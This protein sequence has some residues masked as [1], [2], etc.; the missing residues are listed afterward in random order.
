MGLFSKKKHALPYADRVKQTHAF[1]CERLSDDAL[2]EGLRSDC[3]LE[4][5][6]AT[7]KEIIR[8]KTGLVLFDTQLA[9]AFSLQKGRIAELPTGEGKTLA[10]V[11][12]AVCY[13][14]EGRR[15]H[16]LVFNDYLAK[17]DWQDNREIYAACGLTCG[18]IDQH[19]V[20]KERQAAY[21]CDITYVSA[22]EAGFD[23][24]RDFL[25]MREEDL[26]FPGFD[27]AIVDEADS[28]L[29]DESKTPLVLAGE[30]KFEIEGVYQVNACVLA[31]EPEDIEIEKSEQRVWLT[32]AGYDHMEQLLGKDLADNKNMDIAAEVQS[33]LEAHHL[34]QKDKDYIVKDGAVRIIEPTTGRVV[35]NKRY[36]D[37]LHR[38]VEVKEGLRT[39]PQT[40]V[41][42]SISMQDFLQ[43]YK[44][45]SGMTGTIATSKDEIYESFEL[46]VD[47]VPPHTPCVRNDQP[48]VVCLTAKKHREAVLKQVLACFEKGQPVLM[49]TGSV[50]ESELFSALFEKNA[51]PHVVLNAKNDEAEAELIAGAGAPGAVTISTNM[52]GRGVDIKLGGRNEARRDESVRAGGLYVLGTGINPCVRIDNQLRGRSGRQGDPGESRFFISMEDEVFASRVADYQLVKAQNKPKQLEVIVR[53]VQGEL[54]GEAAE[55]RYMLQRYAFI[56]E[57]QRDIV[58]A[59]R[60]RILKGEE[61]PYLLEMNH[62]PL[63]KK[64]CETAPR[65]G[66]LKAERQL[67]LFY[68]N[69]H[70]ADYLATMEAARSGIHFAVL[71]RRSPIDEYHSIAIG[72]YDE[73]MAEIKQDVL[74]ALDTLPITEN[75]VE[76][77]DDLFRGGTTTWTYMVDER[78]Y[79]FSRLPYL[80]NKVKEKTGRKKPANE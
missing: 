68:I 53:R 34:V 80:I 17:R 67:A 52:A 33:A 28:I 63:F 51:I 54:D 39:A 1:S 65:E 58:T 64:L 25:A 45:L 44:T 3:S 56:L 24:L 6:Y 70:W 20:T 41:F 72:A 26:V 32:D 16:I 27:T 18:Y 62:N 50:A 55:A 35:L 9:T 7:I 42:N 43:Q 66:V 79:Q 60:T 38:A 47:V 8:R 19:A 30:Q 46:E 29:I 31:L 36:P 23:F 75:G 15:V 14:L 77:D 13:A 5:K 37:L 21:A 61:Q 78:L 4:Q 22:K 74:H 59:W 12:A 2:R 76:M 10:A 71:S 69:K 40:L 73:M 57:H 11:V 48:D 49:G